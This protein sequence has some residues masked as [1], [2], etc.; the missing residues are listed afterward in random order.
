MGKVVFSGVVL[1]KESRN[2][3]KSIFN[4][5]VINSLTDENGLDKWVIHC[6]HMTICL[7]ELKDKS[8]LG[9]SVGLR[10][11]ALGRNKTAIAVQVDGFDF[12][13][14]NKVPH[15]TLAV[16]AINGGKPQNSNDILTWFPFSTK[17]L[18]GVVKEVSYDK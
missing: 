5:Y 3:L 17:I 1:D 6:H 8:L 13:I 14:N 15:I 10:V 12:K 9:K 4:S 18:T 7:G 11:K 16:D 2:Y